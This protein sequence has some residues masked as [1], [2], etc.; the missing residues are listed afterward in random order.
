MGE[1]ILQCAD[2]ESKLSCVAT[3]LLAEG[4]RSSIHEVSTADLDD[5]SHLLSLLVQRPLELT[6]S[7]ECYFD[8]LLV[9]SDVHSGG[10]GV[11]GGLRLID[12]IVGEEGLFSFA[13]LLASE[14]MSSIGDDFVDVHVALRT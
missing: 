6:K 4:Q 8:H 3:E 7:W 13:D 12:V 10:E 11:V 14:L 2:A 9:A 1:G 5:I